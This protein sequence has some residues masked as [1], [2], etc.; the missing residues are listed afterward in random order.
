MSDIAGRWRRRWARWDCTN[1]TAQR[2]ADHRPARRTARARAHHRRRRGGDERGA[3]RSRAGR[4]RHAHRTARLTSSRAPKRSS[5]RGGNALLLA[6]LD[7]RQPSARRHRDRAHRFRPHAPRLISLHPCSECRRVRC[8]SMSPSTRAA[9]PRP[10]VP[11]RTVALLR[12]RG[13]RHYCVTNMPVPWRAPPP[14]RYPRTLPTYRRGRQGLAAL[15]RRRA[16]GGSARARRQITT[17]D[18]TDL[19]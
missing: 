13:H 15:A 2:Q 17:P 6:R 1:R 9:S 3:H 7:R 16:E 5:A 10:R 14:R 4:A 19:G 11:P 12:R 18:C 8:W